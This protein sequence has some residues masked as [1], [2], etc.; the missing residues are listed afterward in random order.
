MQRWKVFIKNGDSVA[1]EIDAPNFEVS[2]GGDLVFGTRDERGD[3]RGV[4][5][6]FADGCWAR[7]ERVQAMGE[8]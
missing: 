7:V 6:A 8:N 3:L 4:L 2:N 5:A 1:K